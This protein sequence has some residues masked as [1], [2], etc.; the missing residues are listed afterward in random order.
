[1][2]SCAPQQTPYEAMLLHH[3]PR[4][5][6]HAAISVCRASCQDL[7]GSSSERPVASRLPWKPMPKTAYPH[8]ESDQTQVSR[9]GH[10]TIAQLSARGLPN[11]YDRILPR[12]EGRDQLFRVP[13]GQ[14]RCSEPSA[15]STDFGLL[16]VTTD[17]ES[18][19]QHG[20]EVRLFLTRHTNEQREGRHHPV[21]CVLRA[22]Q[23]RWQGGPTASSVFFPNDAYTLSK[24]R[25]QVEDQGALTNYIQSK[26]DPLGIP[27]SDP[28]TWL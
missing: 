10:R 23:G 26:I 27:D 20:Q 3:W 25:T 9:S 8:G 12:A 19:L 24:V 16:S 15:M 18:P 11:P 7:S 2:C 13:S 5:I 6:G 14:N 28:A 1:M 17:N 4:S 21:R 22:C